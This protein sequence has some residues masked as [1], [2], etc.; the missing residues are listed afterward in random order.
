MADYTIQVVSGASAGVEVT[1]R[2]GGTVLIGRDPSSDLP[3]ND[4]KVSR[5]HAR[6]TNDG[7]E[8]S[9]RDLQSSNGTMVN[10]R[11]ITNATLRQGD[12]IRVGDSELSLREAGAPAAG[13]A[14][15]APPP[16]PPQPS[17]SSNQGLIFGVI[18]AIV[19]IA[20]IGGAAFWF[21]S[22]DSAPEVACSV[23][24]TIGSGGVCDDMGVAIGVDANGNATVNGNVGG[25]E[26]DTAFTSDI[27]MGNLRVVRQDAPEGTVWR[28]DSLPSNPVDP[29]TPTPEPTATPL[30]TAT[31]EP[32]ATPTPEPTPT[33]A[34]T[35]YDDCYVGLVLY[36]GES[37][38]GDGY[39]IT[40]DPNSGKPDGPLSIKYSS[41]D[42]STWRITDLGQYAPAPPP[43]PTP[44]Q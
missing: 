12:T 29:A 31:P 26:I 42:G 43:V 40:I 18:G 33:P 17:S 34:P 8:V 11:P 19:L 27:D 23:G 10:G 4:P 32:T 44:S 2:A 39:T 41:A 38:E 35:V 5:T 16:I 24:M 6:L 14:G 36:P 21:M 28:I 9:L 15:D 30:P 22:Q 1:L 37:C 20:V 25:Q 13:Q 7:R 3:V